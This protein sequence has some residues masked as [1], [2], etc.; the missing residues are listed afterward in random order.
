M[1]VSTGKKYGKT[2]SQVALRWVIQHGCIPIP[3][4]HNKKHIAENM[5][6]FDFTLS[7]EEMEKIDA[8]AKMGQRLRITPDFLGFSD[9]FNFSYE[10]CW[11]EG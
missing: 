6:V 5:N 7:K 3:S 8:K 9:E 11:P 2:A 1:L 10:D 4:S